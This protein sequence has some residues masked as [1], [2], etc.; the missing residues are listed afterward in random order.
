M[1]LPSNIPHG[2]FLN[3]EDCKALDIFIGPREDYMQKYRQQNPTATERFAA[4]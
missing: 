3:E 4:R 1:Y 2:A